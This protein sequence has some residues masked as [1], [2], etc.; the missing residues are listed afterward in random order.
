[1]CDGAG[2]SLGR[3]MNGFSLGGRGIKEWDGVW[4]E[5]GFLFSPKIVGRGWR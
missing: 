1:M 3:S 5:I 4:V 2:A